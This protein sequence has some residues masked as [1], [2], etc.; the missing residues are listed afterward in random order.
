MKFLG[1]IKKYGA[2]RSVS[3]DK[4][5]TI[6]LDV[7]GSFEGLDALMDKPLS[8]TIDEDKTRLSEPPDAA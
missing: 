4:M 2:V 3:G 8:V 7:F 1:T 5:R 6:T